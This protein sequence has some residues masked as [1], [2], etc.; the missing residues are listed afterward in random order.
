MMGVGETH[1]AEPGGFGGLLVQPVYRP[2]GDP[3][4][5]INLTRYIHGP[6]LNGPGC[7]PGCRVLA[8]VGHHR[9][10]AGLVLRPAVHP[11]IVVA[12][13]LKEVVGEFHV[14]ETAMRAGVAGCCHTVLEKLVRAA[15]PGFKVR[16]A[17]QGCPVAMLLEVVCDSV[18]ILRHADA[19][20]PDSVGA[21]MLTGYD[22]CPGR[23][24]DNI[25]VVCT[26]IVDALGCEFINV[27][28][29]GHDATVTAQSIVAHLVCC[30]EQDVS[31]HLANH[32]P[33]AIDDQCLA[34][35]VAGRP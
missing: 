25:V 14:I 8:L 21:N 27:G 23:H 19:V 17:E 13:A 26:T 10:E 4:G 22:R 20:H 12:V 33:P 31:F 30:N 34:G 32:H 5:V 9:I 3:V 28:C 6:D 35:H 15:Q 29:S 18:A 24:A 16:L 1:P 2:V 7:S 11:V